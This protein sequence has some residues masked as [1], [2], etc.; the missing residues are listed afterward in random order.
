M[1]DSIWGIFERDITISKVQKAYSSDHS[2]LRRYL[3]ESQRRADK[4]NDRLAAFVEP[5][6]TFHLWGTGHA[7]FRLLGLPAL[8]AGRLSMATDAN[9]L[10]WGK[11]LA[12]A[13]VIPPD[14]FLA[15]GGKVVVTSAIHKQTIATR[16]RENDW[17]GEIFV[18]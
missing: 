2:T 15:A 7:A 5:G 18:Q 14:A 8:M 9:P 10:Y 11:R 4:L 3:D 13:V 12:G 17:D 6:E 1:Q 16:L